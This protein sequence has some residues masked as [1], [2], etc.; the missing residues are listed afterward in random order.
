VLASLSL[1]SQRQ[2]RER[3]NPLATRGVNV[4]RR[5][6]AFGLHAGRFDLRAEVHRRDGRF[7]LRARDF[8][9]NVWS[10]RLHPLYSL[11]ACPELRLTCW[12]YA[13]TYSANRT[14]MAPR[15]CWVLEY[16]V[17]FS[18]VRYA[19]SLAV[20]IDVGVGWRCFKTQPDLIKRSLETFPRIAWF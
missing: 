10:F 14:T 7:D 16:A 12:P 8:D 13:V 3:S 15:P 9:L 11:G 19:G 17:G 1:R 5:A 4:S 2:R 20:G 6:W 18:G